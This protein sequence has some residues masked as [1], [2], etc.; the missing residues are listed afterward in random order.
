MEMPK[1]NLAAKLEKSVANG[2]GVRYVLWVQG[3]PFLCKG[4]F[5]P[6]FQPFIPREIISA[7]ELAKKIL[8]VKGIEGVTYTGGE[9]M[10]QSKALYF[11]STILKPYNLSIVCYTGFTLEELYHLKDP[12]IKKLLDYIDILIDGR[13]EEENKAN[14]LWRSTSNQ[15]VHFLTDTYIQYKALIEN[16]AT[17]IEF[18]INKDGMTV[19][20]ILQQKILKRLEDIMGE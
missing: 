13:Y 19:T 3:C 2:P 20:G 10:M 9:P 4:C 17:E 18:V 15:R 14:L 6:R 7:E 12:Y 1:L 8:S 5:N 16:N 11:L